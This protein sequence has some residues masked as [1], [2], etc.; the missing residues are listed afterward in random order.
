M[1][2]LHDAAKGYSDFREWHF[3][4][5]RGIF[6]TISKHCGK[7]MEKLELLSTRNCKNHP[8]RIATGRRCVCPDCNYFRWDYDDVC[9]YYGL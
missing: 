7:H 1:I 8:V 4:K 3:A 2:S 6:P 9:G 5:I